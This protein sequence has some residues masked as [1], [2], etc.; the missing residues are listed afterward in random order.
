M[1]SPLFMLRGAFRHPE[2]SEMSDVRSCKG[3]AV[4][5][6]SKDLAPHHPFRISHFSFLIQARLS[7]V[8]KR[9][10]TLRANPQ[11]IYEHTQITNNMYYTKTDAPFEASLRLDH[12]QISHDLP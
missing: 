12:I 9:Q 6:E 10:P 4:R 8:I 2:R 7:H 3:K 1:A 11:T 5:T